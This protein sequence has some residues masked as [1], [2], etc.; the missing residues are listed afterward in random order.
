MSETVFDGYEAHWLSPQQL[1]ARQM[2]FPFASEASFPISLCVCEG[3]HSLPHKDFVGT[4][5]FI[6]FVKKKYRCAVL[7]YAGL[8]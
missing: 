5:S 3:G 4:E 8:K 1:G 7:K 6:Y 2:A